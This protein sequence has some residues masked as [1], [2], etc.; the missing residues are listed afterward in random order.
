MAKGKKN[1][2]VLYRAV[3]FEIHPNQEQE[4]VLQRVSLNL[5]LVWNQAWKERQERYENFFRPI[6]ERIK[7]AREMAKKAGFAGLW[8]EGS[9]K[10]SQ[11]TL[12]NR[13]FPPELVSRAKVALC[14]TE[15]SL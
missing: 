9:V 7:G 12:I 13:G 6:Y 3:R 8:E 14:R 4:S 1:G 15:R 5:R 10:F 11:E 2:D